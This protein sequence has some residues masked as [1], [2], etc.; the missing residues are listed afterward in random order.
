MDL[1]TNLTHPYSFLTHNSNF[2]DAAGSNFQQ[3]SFSGTQHF[4]LS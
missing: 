1:I 2:L 4:M 3:K